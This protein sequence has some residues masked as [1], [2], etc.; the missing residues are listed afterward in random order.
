MLT[1]LEAQHLVQEQARRLPA[2][3]TALTEAVLGQ[4]LA[5]EIQSDLDMPP[6]DKS[7]M[8]G[9]AVRAEDLL[10]GQATLEVIEEV[11]AGRMPTKVVG[12]GQAT[13]IMTG[14]P[15]PQGVDTVVMIE[16]TQAVGGK[17][18]IDDKPAKAGTNIMRRASEMHRGQ[19]V[20]EAGT[21]LRPQE[22]GLL[23]TV[24][25]VEAKVIPAPRLGVMSTGDEVVPPDVI[26]GPGRIRNG[27]GPLLMAQAF[28]AGAIPRFLGI[29][30]DRVDTLQSLVRDGLESD[31]LVLSGG[32]SA[33]K[34]DLVPGVLSDLGV[35]AIFHQVAM[36]PGK[37]VFFGVK[38]HDGGR[39]TLVFGLPGNPVSAMVCFE[40]FVRPAVRLLRG[41]PPG[42]RLVQA[43]LAA[44]F[45]HRTD[46]PTYHPARLAERNQSL[47]VEVVPW[48]GSPDLL[49]LTKAN[50]LVVLPVGDHRHQA[51]Q[52]FAVL[53]TDEWN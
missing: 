13:R 20:L 50:A 14:A 18:R 1:V 22:F 23:A 28:R 30:P 16:R 27:N 41:L 2:V 11:S 33:G 48:L 36:K 26:P 25:R 44:D 17:V 39:R 10:S 53:T 19:T 6:F 49:S 43:I 9:Y 51:G 32:V 15:L 45:A 35:E 40:L 42:P 34:L 5:E 12:P 4:V 24:G 8:D 46:R 47:Q 29:A 3:T 7:M 38:H 37:P 31:L 52:A 21:I